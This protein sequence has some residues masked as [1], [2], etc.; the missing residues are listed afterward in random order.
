MRRILLFAIIG[1]FFV[2]LMSC[3]EVAPGPMK[4]NEVH[5]K[6]P[7]SSDKATLVMSRGWE[8][9]YGS[10]AHINTFLDGKFIGVTAINTYFATQVD[11]GSHYVFSQPIA[12]VSAPYS[13]SK[14]NF[15]AGKTYYLNLQVRQPPFTPMPIVGTFAVPPEEAEV[16]DKTYMVRNPAVAAPADMSAEDK[17]GAIADYEKELKE[18]PDKHKDAVNYK[19]Y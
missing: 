17:S 18:D 1:A 14:L 7:L 6:F 19:G 9:M 16:A 13:I 4:A 3:G 5:P 2:T 10:N 12:L 8:A 11:P 15:E